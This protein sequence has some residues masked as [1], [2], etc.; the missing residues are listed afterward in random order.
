MN[1]KAV[2]L[3]RKRSYETIDEYLDYAAKYRIRNLLYLEGTGDKVKLYHVESRQYHLL[4][5]SDYLG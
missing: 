3:I 5:Y 2:Q 1:G 4:S